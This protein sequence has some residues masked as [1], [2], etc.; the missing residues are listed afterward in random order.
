MNSATLNIK[1]S[2]LLPPP[3]PPLSSEP[4][5]SSPLREERWRLFNVFLYVVLSGLCDI[6]FFGISLVTTQICHLYGVSLSLSFFYSSAFLISPIVFSLPA[7]I[8]TS[9]K[10]IKMTLVIGTGITLLGS[11]L[12]VLINSSFYFSLIGQLIVAAAYP[13]FKNGLTKMSSQWFTAQNRTVATSFLN[14]AGAFI[15]IISM[16]LPTLAINTDTIPT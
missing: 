12:K 8:L 13:F 14:S 5:P 7:G 3:N 11:W 4:P 2:L 16:Y 6:Q 15:N 9:N 1:E 10:T